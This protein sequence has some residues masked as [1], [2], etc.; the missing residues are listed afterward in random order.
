MAP[1]ELPRLRRH[2]RGLARRERGPAAERGTTASFDWFLFYTAAVEPESVER[3]EFG[4]L[5]AMELK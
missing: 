5:Y 4:R 3:I 2:A 1:R